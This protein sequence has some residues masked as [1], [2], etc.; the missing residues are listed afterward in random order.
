MSSTAPSPG[1]IDPIVRPDVG[2]TDW[3]ERFL[4]RYAQVTAE[5]VAARRAL[6]LKAILGEVLIELQSEG[7]VMV[8]LERQQPV[9]H[10]TVARD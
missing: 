5:R 4:I 9:F 1:P 7:A 8:T 2:E 3:L 6:E 10:M